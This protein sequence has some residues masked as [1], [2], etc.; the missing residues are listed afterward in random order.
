[1]HIPDRTPWYIEPNLTYNRWNYTN[2]EEIF[3][4]NALRETILTQRDFKLGL[5][6]GLAVGR[7]G[8]LA[9][10]GAYF[11]HQYRYTNSQNVSLGDTLDGTGFHGSVFKIQYERNSL[12]RKQFASAGS[13]SLFSLQYLRG[14][15]VL[16]PG[17]H[18]RY[19]QVSSRKHGWF[20][21]KLSHEQYYPL[22]AT[23][24]AFR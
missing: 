7:M 13:A 8:R 5:D 14:E 9:G 20:Q 19:D 22:G 11:Y 12:N 1:M 21:M 10:S 24:W 6:V 23:S 4:K 2:I 17:S 3:F 16:N 18:S 15:E